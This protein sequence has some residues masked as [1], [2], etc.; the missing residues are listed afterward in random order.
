MIHFK[1][2]KN[3]IDLVFKKKKL[4][5]EYFNKI[6]YDYLTINCSSNLMLPTLYYE[7]N[8]KDYLKYLPSEFLN[9]IHEIY[10]INKNRNNQL[11]TEV[12]QIKKVFDDNHINHI[13][14]KGSEFIL[15][16]LIK[17]YGLR[18]IGDI[19]I[20]VSE[21]QINKSIT[22]IKKLKYRS[23]YDFKYF[24][25]RHLGR[26]INPNKIFAVEIH[27]NILNDRNIFL[28]K[29]MIIFRFIKKIILLFMQKKLF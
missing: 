23:K 15:S 28:K 19:D 11:M 27:K 17:D 4:G 24:N 26:L 20:L 29:M 13:F 21:N 9:F 14:L 12:K 5:A 3:L 18:M 10:I 6:N 25:H 1:G 8:K 16:G 2:E 7:L 22:L